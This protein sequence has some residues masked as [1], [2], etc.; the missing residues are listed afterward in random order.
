MQDL[1][2]VFFQV[3][4]ETSQTFIEDHSRRTRFQ[5]IHMLS[6]CLH[7][8]V[9]ATQNMM[10]VLLEMQEAGNSCWAAELAIQAKDDTN[11]SV[12]W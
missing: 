10:S 12:Y 5:S 1:S 11:C 6:R 3:L 8:L 4:E 2:S 7:R 9:A